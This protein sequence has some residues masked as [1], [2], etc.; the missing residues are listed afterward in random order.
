[1][2]EKKI[3]IA[4]AG[5]GSRGTS[6]AECVKMMSDKAE[7]VACADIIPEKLERFAKQYGVPKEGCY[8]S[9]EEMLAAGKLAD[10]M[11]ICTMDRD[12]YRFAIPALK[13]GYHLMLEKPASPVPSE[14][15]EIAQVAREENREVLVCH[16]LRYTPF[17][18]KL[19][20]IMQS[21]VLGDVYCIQANEQ[22]TYWHQAH[23][24][25][26]GNWRNSDQ[27]SPMLLQ[28]CCHDM[29]ILLWMTGK[30]CVA[31]SSFGS[32]SHFTAKNAPEGAPDM[33][34]EACPKFGECPYSIKECYYKPAEKGNFGWPLDVV[35]PEPNIEKLKE[36]L[37]TS[38][39]GRCVY[40][41][42]N[43]V[44]DHQ[45]VNILLEDD[46]TISFN[47]CAF[48]SGGGRNI[49]IMGTKGDVIAKMEDNSIQLTL[50]GQESKMVETV[51]ETDAFGH[52]GGDYILV[53]DLVELMNGNRR[54]GL[55]S[56]DDSIESHLLALAAEHS[57]ANGGVLVKLDE[58]DK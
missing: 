42:D 43:N 39:Y 44:V 48:T 29:D 37:K 55:S 41:C 35:E 56:I 7:I 34:S 17:Y 13:L 4:V 46:L 33:C 45:V 16:V 38:Q 5:L 8:N 24:F 30:H 9:A 10:V 53:K 50:F 3:T 26:R 6:Y 18:R 12:H 49:H 51:A 58:F 52:G 11:F 57:R 1:M 40:K 20:E 31:V 14:C 15:R 25:V 28:K 22:V 47:M 23:S 54:E 19:R 27:T 21:G 32:L 36:T 2:S